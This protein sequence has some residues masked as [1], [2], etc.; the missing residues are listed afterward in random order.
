MNQQFS[1]KP[2]KTIIIGYL[3]LVGLA[4]HVVAFGT[5]IAF[6]Q[7]RYKLQ[8]KAAHWVGKNRPETAQIPLNEEIISVFGSWKPVD[9]PATAPQKIMIG[10]REFPDLASAVQAL[11]PGDT[12]QLGPGVYKT[13]LVIKQNGVSLVGKGRVVFDGAVAEG[14]ASIVSKGN[15]FFIQNIECKG[16]RVND[17]NGACIRVEGSNLT[18][19][20]VYF[21]DSQEGILTGKQPGAVVVKDS[22]F[23]SL[24]RN[25]QAHGI[26]T[27]GG[28]LRIEDSLFIASVDEGHEIKSRSTSTDIV[29]TVVASLSSRDSRLIDIPN[30]GRLTIRD[31]V[32]AKGPKSSNGDAI[33]YGLE[34]P[35]YDDNHIEL[36]NNIILLERDQGKNTLLHI[37]G[38]DPVQIMQGN[39]TIADEDPNLSGLNLW[40]ESRKEAG[41]PDY[42]YIPAPIGQTNRQR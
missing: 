21:H 36:V 11:K 15:D 13:P 3:A 17:G 26:Y 19:D 41:L 27:G 7:V 40:I 8:E 20:H 4:A 23:E 16:V 22:R 31:S 25:G 14:K 28:E 33:G 29:R 24:G 39:T 1:C 10:G 32:L 9:S 42:P 12:L 2:Y 30:G 5:L 35:L 18:A 38:G 37:G 6:P 34:K